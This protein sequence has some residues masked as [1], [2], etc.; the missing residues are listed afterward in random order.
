MRRITIFGATG[1]IGQ[2]TLDLIGRDRDTYQVV[3]LTGDQNIAQ[4]VAG[5]TDKVHRSLWQFAGD[6]Y[7]VLSDRCF[8]RHVTISFGA[9]A[10]L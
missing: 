10:A 2:N 5:Q 4:L 8:G 3:A 7:Y 6:R 9:R 1:S